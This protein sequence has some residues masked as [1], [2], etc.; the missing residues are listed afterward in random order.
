[1][2][3]PRLPELTVAIATYGDRFLQLTPAWFPRCDATRYHVCV[4]ATAGRK[5]IAD[6]A[7]ALTAARPD[8]SI[9]FVEGR[10][11][12]RN[13]N[14]ALAAAQTGILLFADDDL[15]LYPQN[16]L[17]LRQRFAAS[18]D[19]AFLCCRVIT[20][21]GKP[22]KAYGRDGQMVT[23]LNAARVGTPELALRPQMLR[24]RGVQFDDRFGAG[25]EQPFGDEFIFLCDALRAGLRGQ[26]AALTLAIH[27][28]ESSGM[29]W[30]ATSFAQRRKMF[31]RA[32]G[33]WSLPARCA[34]ALKHRRRFPDIQS[35]WRFLRP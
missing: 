11:A 20:P 7:A 13:R 28:A 5:D 9:S 2:T 3:N 8:I 6:H 33:P 32:L 1:M 27:P 18:P 21:D 22:R 23:R 16:Y 31:N 29:T 34:F 15:T 25:T 30:D 24:Q 17:P 19:L 10:G 26:H 12:A 35:L 14:A 4:Q